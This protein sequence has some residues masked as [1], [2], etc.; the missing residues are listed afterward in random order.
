MR[1]VF[2]VGTKAELIKCMPIMLE[3]QKKREEYLF[4]HTGQHSLQNA[5]QEFSIK[6]PDFIL[7]KEPKASTKFWSKIDKSSVLWFLLTI[8]KIKKLIKKLAP[9]YVIYHGDTMSSAAAA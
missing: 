1:I 3:L 5:C 4:I 6:K 9:D 8:L 7:S 2:V